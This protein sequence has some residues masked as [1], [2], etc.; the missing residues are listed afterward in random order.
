MILHEKVLSKSRV[1]LYQ[2]L[3][4]P[5]YVFPP[6]MMYF[7]NRNFVL[8]FCFVVRSLEIFDIPVI[9]LNKMVVP[10]LLIWY[11]NLPKLKPANPPTTTKF[12]RTQLYDKSTVL[13]TYVHNIIKKPIWRTLI[14]FKHN[15]PIGI[16]KFTVAMLRQNIFV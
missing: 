5:Y 6:C 16:N 1:L 15:R 9:P 2:R 7:F 8:L 3:C 11:C 14:S 12:N 10:E 4:I 13:K